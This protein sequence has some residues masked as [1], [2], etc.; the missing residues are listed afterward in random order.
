[1][2][3]RKF[4]IWGA[5]GVIGLMPGCRA[6]R[7]LALPRLTLIHESADLTTANGQGVA[8]DG[9]HYYTNDGSRTF[10]GSRLRKFTRNG[11]TY[12]QVVSVNLL[13]ALPTE[14]RQVNSIDYHGGKLWLGA[15]NFV[16]VPSDPAAS[17]IV[18]VDPADLNVVDIYELEEVAYSEGG[19]WKNVGSGDEFWAIFHDTKFVSRY[20]LIDGAMVKQAEY[21]LPLIP[22]AE[23]S[24]ALNQGAQW[25]GNQLWT[26]LHNQHSQTGT[27]IHKW[28]GSG[29]IGVGFIPAL[30]SPDEAG[31]G[32]HW[33]T[34]GEVML[35]AVRGTDTLRILRAAVGDRVPIYRRT[36]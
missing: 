32:L 15:S 16:T 1:M 35:F 24:G 20:R 3:R 33:E 22:D 6:R 8:F 2:E 4:L 26:Q 36:D 21:N 7:G 29:F 14:I 13:G 17:W 10:S 31:Q 11:G 19:V 25:L 27:Y 34:E 18:E 9:T 5:V 23:G 28:T 12:T 30:G